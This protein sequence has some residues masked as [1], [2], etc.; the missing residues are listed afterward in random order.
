MSCT[1]GN[2]N[3]AVVTLQAK[4][5]YFQGK[6]YAESQ[7]EHGVFPLSTTYMSHVLELKL[8]DV[9]QDTQATVP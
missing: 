7:I 2:I 1:H 8:H 3:C 6:Y 5:N 4:P 9:Y